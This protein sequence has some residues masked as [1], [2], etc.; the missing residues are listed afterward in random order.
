MRKN[1]KSG[2]DEAQILGRPCALAPEAPET[3]KAS[4]EAMPTS[5]GGRAAWLG[6][7]ES[8]PDSPVQSRLSYH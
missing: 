6:D 8:N 5:A 4:K 1:V 3:K 7:R 2:A